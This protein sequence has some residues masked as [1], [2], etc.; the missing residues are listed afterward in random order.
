MKKILRLFAVLWAVLLL[1][2]G[3]DAPVLS[4]PD[5]NGEA[6]KRP[7]TIE[8]Y[9]LKV[10]LLAQDDQVKENLYAMYA[11][12][13]GFEETCYLP[14]PMPQQQVQDQL[15]L[16]CYE[17]PEL[18]QVDL[19]RPTS[20]H[21]YEGQKDVIAVDFPYCMDKSTYDGMLAQ[22]K[23]ALSAFNTTG[24]DILEAEKY[25]YDTLCS[26]ITYD[27][28]TAHC[29]NVYGAL[30][31][32]RAKC[33]GIAKTMKW[34]MEQAGFS[35]MCVG[36]EPYDGGI[37]HAWNILPVDGHYYHLDPT[38]D[39]QSGDYREPLYPAYNVSADF[40]T[41]IYAPSECFTFQPEHSMDASYHALKGNFFQ[42]DD[43]WKS[44]VK[45]LFK[46]AYKENGAFTVQF[47]SKSTYE[48]C[49]DSLEDLF[50]EAAKEAGI[51]SWSW[52]TTY[53]DQYHLINV[54]I[55]K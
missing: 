15:T 12:I 22:A 43:N 28:A 23:E 40:M 6:A 27:A 47:A 5:H 25:I 42:S 39:V 9:D 1:F 7:N 31:E 10:F 16:L 54:T 48:D 29:G 20:Y 37:G 14:Y 49:L 18:F 44:A 13:M 34:A 35:C 17:C 45:K 50:R 32:G 26:R 51:T 19:S 4:T 3:C 11:A 33:D 21:S 52:S 24:M 8:N 36:G 46:S 55:Q 2:S 53:V 30:I 38:A 41:A